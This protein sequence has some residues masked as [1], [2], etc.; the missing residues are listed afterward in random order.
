MGS[1]IK[2]PP[3]CNK[4]YCMNCLNGW[5]G[6]DAETK[7]SCPA[8]QKIC[9]C[10]RCN[11][12]ENLEKFVQILER[13]DG[14]IDTLIINSPASKMAHR[15]LQLFPDLLNN[16]NQESDENS[17]KHAAKDSVTKN[18]AGPVKSE[19]WSQALA[20]HNQRYKQVHILKLLVKQ[21]LVEPNNLGKRAQEAVAGCDR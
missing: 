7:V 9:F 4:L 11:R 13:L 6:M 20:L 14:D 18:G 5:Y 12:F 1:R 15:L 21:V 3:G 17:R 16:T 8:C 2:T 19:S 10:T